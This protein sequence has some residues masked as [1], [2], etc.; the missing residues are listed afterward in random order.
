MSDW[1][2]FEK[3]KAITDKWRSFLSEQEE[4]Q[5]KQLK[6]WQKWLARRLD[7]VANVGST[8]TGRGHRMPDARAQ[9]MYGDPTDEPGMFVRWLGNVFNPYY[10]GRRGFHPGSEGV[11]QTL[12]LTADGLRSSVRSDA[13]GIPEAAL[14]AADEFIGEYVDYITKGIIPSGMSEQA[15]PSGAPSLR[16]LQRKMR[17]ATLADPEFQKLNKKQKEAI[18]LKLNKKL[19]ALEKNLKATAKVMAV[20]AKKTKEN[21][22]AQ[23]DEPK[24]PK[25]KKLTAKTLPKGELKKALSQIRNVAKLT[26]ESFANQ[27]NDYFKKFAAGNPLGGDVLKKDLPVINLIVGEITKILSGDFSNLVQESNNDNLSVHP[28]TYD[29]FQF[30]ISEGVE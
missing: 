16:D 29:F 13:E 28:V 9:E 19:V 12:E 27:I 14:E 30:I 8:G 5:Q 17:E 3:N 11:E 10:V 26:P 1:S 15:A 25:D 21:P 22:E 18:L 23:N 20:S 24:E 6:P 4:E 2:S 7:Y